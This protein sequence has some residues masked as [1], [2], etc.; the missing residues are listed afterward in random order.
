MKY[1]ERVIVLN[2]D[3]SFLSFTNF[4]NAIKLMYMGKAEP[5]NVKGFIRNKV[6]SNFE[7][8]YKYVCPVAI[9]LLRY[10]REIYKKYVPCNKSN[11]INRDGKCMYCGTHKNLTVDHIIPKSRGGKLSWE[12]CVTSCKECNNRKGDRT[13]SEAKMFLLEQPHMPTIN[14]F[15]QLKMKRFGVDKFMESLF[16]N[17]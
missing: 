11:I 8:T 2:N 4:K 17:M 16:K 14:E 12:N 1:S 10:V 5:I 15:I 13:P 7:G 6:V 3:F 9:R